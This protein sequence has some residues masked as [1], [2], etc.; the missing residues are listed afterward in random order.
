MQLNFRHAGRHVEA[1]TQPEGRQWRVVIGQRSYV[2]DASDLDE[3]T[4]LLNFGGRQYT[5]YVARRGTD[6][7]VQMRGEVH[8]F[9]VETSGGAQHELTSL[10]DPKIAAPMPGK[11]LQVL[12]GR[13]AKVETGDGL[14]ILEAMKMEN[15]LVAAAPAT[16]EEVRVE[17]GQTVDAGQ[18][19]IVLRYELGT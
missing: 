18:V 9:S 8:H 17:P 6:V 4:L 2:I 7:F 3:Q 15:L 13:G 11:V 1:Q 5:A 19:L 14:L 10:A 16:V 12:V